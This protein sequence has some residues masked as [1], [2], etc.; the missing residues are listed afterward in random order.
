MNNKNKNAQK[1]A[2]MCR[3]KQEC[4]EKN[5]YIQQKQDCVIKINVW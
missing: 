3:K 5:K 1:K 4:A 2:R